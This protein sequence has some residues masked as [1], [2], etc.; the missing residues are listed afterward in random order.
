M[1]LTCI[2]SIVF[3]GEIQLAQ[4][5]DITPTIIPILEDGNRAGAFLRYFGQIALD[6]ESSVGL[7]SQSLPVNTSV[8]LPESSSLA[9]FVEH[10][11]TVSVT[12]LFF[13]LPPDPLFSKSQKDFTPIPSEFVSAKRVD[14]HGTDIEV[15]NPLTE[16]NP[17]PISSLEFEKIDM[18]NDTVI[19]IVRQVF[20]FETNIVYPESSCSKICNL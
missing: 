5:S 7:S 18:T 17:M 20:K 13:D 19:D 1:N 14:L 9:L 16:D 2:D 6:L 11:P 4:D 12:E 8:E 15:S 10:V 3:V